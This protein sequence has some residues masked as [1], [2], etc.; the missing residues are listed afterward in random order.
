MIKAIIFDCF[1]VLSTEAWLPFKTKHFAYDRELFEQASNLSRQAD[2]GLISHEDFMRA[3]AELAH[4]TPTEA[5]KAIA[6]NV[7]DEQLFAYINE[8]KAAYKIGLLSNVAGDYLYQIFSPDQLALFDT[9]TLSFESGFIKPQEQAFEAAAK[10]LGLDVSECVFI[11]DQQRNIDG[12][13]AAGMLAIL[14]HDVAQ[15]QHKL[16]ALLKA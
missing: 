7:P 9:M 15:L 6:R 10:Q 5:I 2:R 13:H 1:G 16:S 8:L 12:A 4:I 14:Y 11:D 3:I